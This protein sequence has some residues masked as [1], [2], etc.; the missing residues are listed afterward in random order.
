VPA[1]LRT[2]SGKADTGLSDGDD[3]QLKWFGR[4]RARDAQA[5]GVGSCGVV[6]SGRRPI[7]KTR[8]KKLEEEKLKEKARGGLLRAGFTIFAMMSLCP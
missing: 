1:N 3:T 4:R 5:S 7:R 6:T 8:R 2:S